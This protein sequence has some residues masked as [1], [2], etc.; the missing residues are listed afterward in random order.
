MNFFLKIEEMTKKLFLLLII[1]SLYS[2]QNVKDALS[3]KKYESS[4]EFLVIKKNPLVLPPDFNKL[5]TPE[6]PVSLSREES[7]EAEID[8]IVSS[9]KSDEDLEIKVDN[10]TTNSSTEDFVLDQIKN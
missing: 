5:P 9:M 7:I 1:I 4:D 8:D 3:G 6:D 10:S 2:C